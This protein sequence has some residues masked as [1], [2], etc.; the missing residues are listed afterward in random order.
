M[1]AKYSVIKHPVF[2]DRGVNRA[3]LLISECAK[4]IEIKRSRGKNVVLATTALSGHLSYV[5][6]TR[7]RDV[8]EA[9]LQRRIIDILGKGAF[10]V[11]LYFKPYNDLIPTPYAQRRIVNDRLEIVP[12]TSGYFWDYVDLA[13]IIILPTPATTLLETASSLKKKTVIV[14]T[15]ADQGAIC[16][17]ACKKHWPEST[18]TCHDMQTFLT[19]IQKSVSEDGASMEKDMSPFR[20]QFL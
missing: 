3:R 13:D 8:V 2:H 10:P 4:K 16:T 7:Q 14:Y 20:R 15:A 1:P 5:S 6:A 11:V 9:G 18:T 17:E 12:F 19:A